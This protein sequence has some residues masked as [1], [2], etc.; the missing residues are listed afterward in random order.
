MADPSQ[1][2]LAILSTFVLR[3][4]RVAAHSL[5]QDEEVFRGLATGQMRIEFEG[6]Q[7]F[8]VK[9]YPPEEQIESAAARVRPLLLQGD[10]THWAKVLNA[11]GFFAK[12][13]ASAI[14]HLGKLRKGWRAVSEDQG[15]EGRSIQLVSPDGKETEPTSDLKLAYAYIYGDVVHH[16]EQRIAS[17]EGF[18]ITHR[19]EEAATLVARIMQIAILTLQFTLE[20]ARVGL[21][22]FEPG[23]YTTEVVV[24]DTESRRPAQ[25]WVAPEGTVSPNHMSEQPGAGWSRMTPDLLAKPQDQSE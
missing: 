19:F 7:V 6:D 4:R 1:Q 18:D 20:L 23:V 10:P 25:A 24:T 5:V 21:I 11:L 15:D 2:Q 9:Q 13:N 8:I 14:E 12:G 22:P 17:V 16:D 3:A